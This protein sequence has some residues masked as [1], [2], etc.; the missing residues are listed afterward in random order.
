V[1]QV[2]L[3]FI[4]TLSLCGCVRVEQD[5]V[6]RP[7][8]SGSL[9][10]VYGVKEQ[11]LERMRQVA[12]QMAAIDPS[13][14]ATDVDWLTAFDEN[15]I[16][17]EWENME[18]DGVK[19]DRVVTRTQDGWRYMQAE[20]QFVS[21]QHLL[22][23]GMLADGHISLTRGPNGQY[24]YQQSIQAGRVMKSL[25]PGMEMEALQPMLAMM[26]RDFNA[27]FSVQ[28]PGRIIRSNAHRTEGSRVIW[29]FNGQ[30]AD[31]VEKLQNLDLRMMFDGRE[32]KISDAQSK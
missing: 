1:K 20:I 17:R 29:E 23:C 18:H 24:G 13:L 28:A 2:Y 11:D 19:L 21:L 22:D 27:S 8:G 26:M 4:L 31:V 6:I 14:A 12:T 5:L 30:Q 9:R 32:L 7:D 15:V 25:P 10:F 16:R 3:L